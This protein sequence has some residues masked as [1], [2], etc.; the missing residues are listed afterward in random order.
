MNREKEMMII[1]LDDKDVKL[2]LVW[3][4]Y[5]VFEKYYFYI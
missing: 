3:N 1:C 5:E 4:I 2:N